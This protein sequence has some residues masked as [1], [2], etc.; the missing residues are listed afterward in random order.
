MLEVLLAII[1]A[2]GVS[3][4]LAKRKG[5]RRRFNL[6]RIR[7]TDEQAL[8]T[9]TS[10]TAIVGAL[11]GA[12]TNAMRVVSA[13]MVWSLVNLTANEGPITVGYAHGDY[14][15]TEI[16][17]CLE[18][19]ASA[20]ASNKIANE[21]ANRLVRIVGTFGA[22]AQSLND[23]RPIKTKLNWLIT[24]GVVLNAFVYNE[25]TTGLTTGA[26]LHTQGNLWV[27]DSV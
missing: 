8:G 21:Q 2:L 4:A 14:S 5:R 16:K 1:F 9:L 6:R 13:S 22:G 24:P 7:V 19:Q 12:I 27:K 10:D 15:V 11:H 23:G 26:Y 3:P 17:E 18:A 25:D 20:D